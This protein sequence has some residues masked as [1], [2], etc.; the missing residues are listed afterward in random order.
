M[1]W[2]P[3]EPADA[4]IFSTAP[5]LFRFPIELPV[6]PARVWWSL[7]SDESLAAWPLGPGLSLDV[8]WTSP[9]PFGV[10]TT[11]QVRLPLGAVTFWERFF[12][13]DDGVGYSFYVERVDR[14]GLRRF[15]EDYALQAHG[16][17]TLLTWTVALVPS[18]QGARL[19]GPAAPLTRLVFGRTA[20]AA[21][22]YFA[23]A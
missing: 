4:S 11:R 6:P 18:P 9:R 15:A 17:G 5:Q 20:A 23:Q 19:L 10:G 13:W 22:A 1:A 8:R 14:P 16:S 21:R 7:A 3:L 12:R 2:H